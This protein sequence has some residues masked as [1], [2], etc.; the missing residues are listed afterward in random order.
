M[1]PV[2]DA[3]LAAI[4]G[5]HQQTG[6]ALVCRPS[7]DVV[8]SLPVKVGGSVTADSTRSIVRSMQV[9]LMDEDRLYA[10]RQPGDLLHPWSGNEVRLVSTVTLADGGTEDVPLGVFRPEAGTDQ[11]ATGVTISLTGLDRAG[12]VAANAWPYTVSTSGKTFTQA[13]RDGLLDRYPTLPVSIESTAA[14]A[15]RM[16]WF[17]YN[18]S[19]PWRDLLALAQAAGWRLGIDRSGVGVAGTP[20]PSP[21][22][23][24]WTE[25]PTCTVTKVTRALPSPNGPNGV[26]GIGGNERRGWRAEA[27]VE[28]PTH[29]LWRGGSYGEV[30]E[31]LRGDSWASQADAQAAVDARLAEILSTPV[32][33]SVQVTPDPALDPGD[34]VRLTAPTSGVFGDFEVIKTNFT[35]GGVM[36][37]DL[38][39][40]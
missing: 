10:P 20:P 15:P 4:A 5:S 1:Y 27:W 14:L 39:T 8:A 30:C 35:F 34:R 32:N 7:G 24:E 31:V 25:G 33:V 40:A 21:V 11:D 23:R 26:V 29:P 6:T 13:L 9:E 2:S 16:V 17:G 18:N 12:R 19:D 38:V 36:D 22:V 37:V 28:D 3:Y